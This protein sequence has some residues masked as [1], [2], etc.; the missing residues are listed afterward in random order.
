MPRA[1]IYLWHSVADELIPVA[2]ADLLAA[3]YCSNGVPLTYQRDA[4][5]EH[6]SYAAA[7][8]PAAIA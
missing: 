4:A 5:G 3:T 7:G 8:A 6:P 2:G 1:S